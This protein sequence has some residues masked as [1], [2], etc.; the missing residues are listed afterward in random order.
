[1]EV[2][3]PLL[4]S[5]ALFHLTG[6]H[7]PTCPHLSSPL[8]FLPPF[9]TFQLTSLLTSLLT[10]SVCLLIF[11]FRHLLAYSCISSLFLSLK[12]PLFPP[13]LPN[14]LPHSIIGSLSNM[15]HPTLV[16]SRSLLNG[17]FW[18]F[19]ATFH[20]SANCFYSLALSFQP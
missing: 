4:P 14:S 18:L 12:F 11:S 9:L 19:Y 16:Y 1:M 2:R 17:S 10:N 8:H 6:N 3:S 13:S 7:P 5:T 20:T 15:F